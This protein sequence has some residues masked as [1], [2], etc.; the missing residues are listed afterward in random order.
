[1]KDF[2]KKISFNK[3]DRKRVTFY[4]KT[5]EW[6]QFREHCAKIRQNQG[7]SQSEIINAFIEDFND[8]MQGA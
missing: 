8:N 3:I 4:V 2:L 6:E 5:D 7:I 1:M